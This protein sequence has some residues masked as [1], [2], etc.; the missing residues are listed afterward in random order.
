MSYK[1]EFKFI[2]PDCGVA[3]EF[4]QL[5]PNQVFEM[6][7]CLSC[8]AMFFHS[9]RAYTG[10]KEDYTNGWYKNGTGSDNCIRSSDGIPTLY[11]DRVMVVFT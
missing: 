5:T 9:R 3:L 10:D 1:L 2:C 6:F 11:D 7:K 8:R 4:L